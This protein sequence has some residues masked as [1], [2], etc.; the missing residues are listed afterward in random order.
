MFSFFKET[1]SQDLKLA[2]VDLRAQAQRTHQE[3]KNESTSKES[4]FDRAKMKKE[5]NIKKE[6]SSL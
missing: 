6:D 2:R 4:S 1:Q 3:L 5:D